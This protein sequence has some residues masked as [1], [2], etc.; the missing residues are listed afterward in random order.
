MTVKYDNI[1]KSEVPHSCQGMRM[2]KALAV[3]F[4]E[5]SRSTLQKWLKQGLIVIDNEVPGQRDQVQG[6]EFVE[7]AVPPSAAVA[8]LPQPIPLAIVYEDDH[9][10][11][12]NKPAGLIV[13]PGAGN[14]DGTLVNGL[15]NYDEKLAD[16]PRAGIVHR[17]DKGTTGLMVVARSEPARLGLIGQLAKRS[18]QRTY[19]GVVQGVPVS[20]G[21]IDEPIGRDHHDRRRMMV[22]ATGKPAV[23]HYRM[24]Q[25]FRLH[26]LLRCQLDTGRTHQIR[27]HLKHIGYPLVGDPTYG[28]RNR[29][30]P[31]SSDE[32]RE[33]LRGF[34]RQA[35]HAKRLVIKHPLTG[36]HLEWSAPL[37]VDMAELVKILA[38]D[39]QGKG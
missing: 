19:L 31:N 37:P 9:L 24:E 18:L 39:A 15:L 12:I 10:L 3:L 38:Q 35:L 29:L 8:W 32:L 25:R 4:P 14:P 1:L 16:L 5:Y 26:A 23:T 2:D 27:V 17:L 7:L 34:S 30:P 36:E 21:D 20:G 28:G 33:V 13:H 6:G 11:V 22:S